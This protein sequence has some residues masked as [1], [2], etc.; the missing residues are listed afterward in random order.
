MG[1]H[2]QQVDRVF[3]IEHASRIEQLEAAGVELRST[4]QITNLSYTD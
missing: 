1:I 2:K 4:R 3:D